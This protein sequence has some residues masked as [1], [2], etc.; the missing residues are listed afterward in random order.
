MHFRRIAVFLFFVF[1]LVDVLTAAAT[2]RS[3]FASAIDTITAGW[4]SG[5]TANDGCIWKGTSPFCDGGCAVVGHVV[6]QT[7]TI[8]DGGNVFDWTQSPLLPFCVA[9]G[10]Q[11][12]CVNR[13]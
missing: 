8:G 3:A 4:G 6:R 10:G 5:R 1:S 9:N 12:H 7:S 2:E 11:C 13:E